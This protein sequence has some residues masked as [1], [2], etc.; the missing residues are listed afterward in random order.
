MAP[1]FMTRL[2]GD[3]LPKIRQARA[4]E[5]SIITTKTI[6]DFT[7]VVELTGILGCRSGMVA[8]EQPIRAPDGRPEQM[9]DEY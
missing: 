7:R 1:R 5:P 4:P 8:D 9:P 3:N 6:A 2:T